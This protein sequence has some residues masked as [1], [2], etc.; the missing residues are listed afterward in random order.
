MKFPPLRV[1]KKSAQ[2]ANIADEFITKYTHFSDVSY[3]PSSRLLG[4]FTRTTNS[5]NT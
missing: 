4:F 2:I 5:T 3:L 1:N